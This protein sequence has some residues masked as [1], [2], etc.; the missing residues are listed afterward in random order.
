MSIGEKIRNQVW[1]R[2]ADKDKEPVRDW[3]A[4]N[5]ARNAFDPAILE[6]PAT[7]VLAAV[8]GH[9]INYMPIQV[10]ALLESIG[11]NPDASALEVATGVMEC[12]KAASILASAAGHGELLFMASDETTAKGAELLGF[13][14][15]PFKLYR[16]RL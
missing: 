8:N 1:V 14:E 16:R 9:I 15:V 13:S 11:V 4:A 10:V 5:S 3:C 7:R 2:F 6:Y 12:V